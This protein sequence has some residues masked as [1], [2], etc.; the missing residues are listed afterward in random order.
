M[1][2]R[3][4]SLGY[5]GSG[6]LDLGWDFQKLMMPS[7]DLSFRSRPM[8]SRS[9]FQFARTSTDRWRTQ[10]A[11]IN[12][13]PEIQ[14][15]LTFEP[16]PPMLRRLVEMLVKDRS[17]K[18]R[19]RYLDKDGG[20]SWQFDEIYF[21]SF[22]FDVSEHT[23]LSVRMDF[24]VMTDSIS[25][26]WD[27]LE[28]NAL[29]HDV[30]APISL[31]IGYYR[32][33][34]ADGNNYEIKDVTQFSLGFS[35]EVIPQYECRGKNSDQAPV[36]RHVHFNLPSITFGLSQAMHLKGGAEYGDVRTQMNQLRNILDNE[37]TLVFSLQNVSNQL[38]ERLF[39]LTGVKETA[40]TPELIGN[41]FKIVK[42]EYTV[43]GAMEMD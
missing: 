17:R 36:A 41:G 2:T 43:A 34:I 4:V 22:S 13:V 3:L 29:G 30:I 26:G 25:H 32:W 15:S 37:N 20:I 1:G 33:R 5:T 8:K 23:V 31:P 24:F 16:E 39:Y 12:D 35:Q 27:E 40:A 28:M 10:S 18:L 19:F 14:L 11:Y 6:W 9:V 42:R 38:F 7:C 21:S